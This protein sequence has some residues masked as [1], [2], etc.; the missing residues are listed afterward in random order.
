MENESV[1]ISDARGGR[2]SRGVPLDELANYVT[3]S[4]N[5]GN[6]RHVISAEIQLPIDILRRGLFF[7]DT[8]GIG[9]IAANTATTRHFLPEAD[10]AI[11]VTAFDSPLGA[12]EIEFLGDALGAAGKVF[13][14]INKRDLVSSAE[15]AELIEYIRGRLTAEFGGRAWGLF[16]VSA[17]QALRGK[18]EHN[19]DTLRQSGLLDLEDA[20][21]RF[22][23]HE[24]AAHLLKRALDRLINLLL[25]EQI[26][27]S[28]ASSSHADSPKA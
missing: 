5:P 19:R 3:E 9:A 15:K 2:F 1:Y 11:F 20:L 4:G 28:F 26:E 6:R 27:A 25:R 23:T 21:L 12:S 16:A 18:L 14:V 17:R 10:A 13:V 8:P 22:L 24:K 7:T